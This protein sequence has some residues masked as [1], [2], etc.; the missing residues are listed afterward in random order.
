MFCEEA[1][2]LKD[3]VPASSRYQHTIDWTKDPS[4]RTI[5][6]YRDK[7]EM[8]ADVIEKKSKNLAKTTPGPAG[9][10]HYESWKKT[11]RKV[12]GT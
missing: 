6:F 10:D 11:L 9:Y 4:T 3:K 5:K 2:K 8:I 1:S 7:R 12:S